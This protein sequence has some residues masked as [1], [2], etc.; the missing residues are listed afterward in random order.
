MAVALITG[1]S[2]RI[3][4]GA[5][6]ARRLAEAGMDLF[7]HSWSPADAEQPWGADPE[8]VAS[9][10]GELRAGGARVAHLAADLADP[11]AP[12]HL[13]DAA[14]KAF[15]GVDALVANHARSSSFP[16]EE[17]TAAELDLTYA[18]NT[19]ATLLLVK[20][21]ARQAAGPG[22]VVLMTSGQ[23]RGPMPGEL[24]YIASKG[25]LHQL[26]ASLAAH[27]A[28][29]GITVNCVDPGATDT[30]YADAEAHAAVRALEPMGRWGEPDDAARLIA[31]LTSDAGRWVTGQVLVSNG[32]GP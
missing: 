27:L 12:A 31:W 8:G 10:A 13:V 5:A 18:V 14:V 21:F 19:R 6:V 2:R 28:P 16:L 7:L 26:T 22:R 17:L 9:I 20:E 15:G 24:P 25:A 30:G 23:H 11:D 4:I 3:G 29:R 1:V 32:G